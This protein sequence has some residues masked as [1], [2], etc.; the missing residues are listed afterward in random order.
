[1]KIYYF[2]VYIRPCSLIVNHP[3]VMILGPLKARAQRCSNAPKF[4]K[5]YRVSSELWTLKEHHVEGILKSGLIVIFTDYYRKSY[6]K[7]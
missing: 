1:M 5:N 2:R 3:F 4:I 6:C 7:K